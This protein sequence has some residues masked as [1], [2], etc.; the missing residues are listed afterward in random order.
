MSVQYGHCGQTHFS[1][2]LQ[3]SVWLSG[4]WCSSCRWQS[5]AHTRGRLHNHQ[6]NWFI[7]RLN[8]W[9]IAVVWSAG[10]THITLTTKTNEWV[11][12][13]EH[14]CLTLSI[15]LKRSWIGMNRVESVQSIFPTDDYKLFRQKRSLWWMSTLPSLYTLS[16]PKCTTHI[17]Q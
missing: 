3:L 16:T 9:S 13:C 8:Y 7:S 14:I 17:S 12:P 10:R 15:F 5:G 2:K 4:G 6:R 11:L 1:R